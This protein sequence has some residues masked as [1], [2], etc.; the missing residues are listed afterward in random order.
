MSAIVTAMSAPLAQSRP[1]SAATDR[2]LARTATRN[3]LTATRNLLALPRPA[4]RNPRPATRNLLTATRNLLALPRP[5]TRC[6]LALALLLACAPP[7]ESRP[8]PPPTPPAQPSRTANN[9]A[10]GA[11]VQPD[12]DGEAALLREQVLPRL[13]D[14]LPVD[15]RRACTAMLDAAATFY[16]DIEAEPAA[17][18]QILADLA[19]TRDAELLGCERETSVRAASCVQLRLGDRDAELPWLLDQCSRAFPD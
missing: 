8:A 13:P 10:R 19:A 7:A 11:G 1:P 14:P 4:T 9:D 3:L 2:T 17:R 5:A 16:A 12:Y 6:P 18:A 15:R